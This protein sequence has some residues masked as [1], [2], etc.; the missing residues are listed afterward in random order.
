MSFSIVTVCTGNVCRSPLGELLLA[1]DL[2]DLP[3]TV[4]SAG[5]HALVG[6]GMPAQAQAIARSLG[7]TKSE[8]HRGRQITA[9]IVR[10][11]DLVLPMALE[12]RRAV[13]ELVPRAAAKTFTIREFARIASAVTDEALRVAVQGGATLEERLRLAVEQ[14]G[15]SRGE[16][17]PPA[18]PADDEVIDPYRRSDQVYAESAAQLTPAVAEVVSLLR[19]AAA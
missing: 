19:R 15:F 10:S 2:A 16:V 6:E 18:S 9:D 12:H 7:V 1:K 5:V 11:A 4:S 17:P 8:A 14:I 3:I 13:V